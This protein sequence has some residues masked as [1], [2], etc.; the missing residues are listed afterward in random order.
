MGVS[1]SDLHNTLLKE[2][3]TS[4]RSLGAIQSIVYKVWYVQ[5]L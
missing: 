2:M 1:A 4:H 3:L 5:E